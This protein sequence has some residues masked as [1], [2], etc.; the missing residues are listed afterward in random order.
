V[1][2]LD[3]EVICSDQAEHRRR[4]ESRIADIPGHVVPTWQD[5]IERDYHPW[6]DVRRLIVDTATT[7]VDEAVRIIS[8][9]LSRSG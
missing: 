4:V 7:T 9:R 3:V 5:V 8:D 2:S 6:D 1:E